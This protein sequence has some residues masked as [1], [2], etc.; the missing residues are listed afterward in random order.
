M[1]HLALIS[2]LALLMTSCGGTSSSLSS[3]SS[4]LSSSSSPSS[5]EPINYPVVQINDVFNDNEFK[6]KKSCW[7]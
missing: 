5:S 3:N 4:D 7:T 1:K 6:L 2:L